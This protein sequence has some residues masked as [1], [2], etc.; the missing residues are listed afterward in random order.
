MNRRLFLVLGIT[1]CASNTLGF[2]ANVVAHGWT[3]VSMLFG[4]CSFLMYLLFYIG[5]T[6]D[7]M[8]LTSFWMIVLST[9]VEFP[10]MCYLYGHS[11]A[12]YC[13]FG[14]AVYVFFL[15]RPVREVFLALALLENS[16]ALFLREMIPEY[17]SVETD[18][19]A[20]MTMWLSFVIVM[21]VT[22]ALLIVIRN[23]IDIQQNNMMQFGA[24]IEDALIHDALTGTY[25]R[26][27]MYNTFRTL[28]SGG[29]VVAVLL[30]IDDF[31][32]LNDT[33]GHVF[34]D[35]V[36]ATFAQA[37]MRHTHGC[38]TVFRFG[39]EEFLIL[40]GQ[41]TAADALRMCEDACTEFRLMFASAKHIS[42][43]CSGG[44]VAC[45]EGN[46]LEWALKEADD[47]LYHA[48]NN[49]KNRIV[50]EGFALPH[51]PQR[52]NRLSSAV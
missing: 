29:G 42:I 34:G 6:R 3:R 12:V 15:R 14:V 8:S 35:E 20:F 28:E 32:Q 17:T 36:L 1:A 27:Y 18:R 33:F 13:I 22:F 10:V 50:C 46:D 41:T 11:R 23:M 44:L 24:H 21:V 4:I 39:G 25:N 38:G 9:L 19:V 31:K 5:E 48:K 51:A 47:R 45:E 7:K 2:I 26:Q 16:L 30:D 40:F 49:G 43:T 37:L 52:M